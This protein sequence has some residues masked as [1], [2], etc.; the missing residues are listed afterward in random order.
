M[1][2]LP[3]CLAMVLVGFVLTSSSYAQKDILGDLNCDGL[4]NDVDKNDLSIILFSGQFDPDADLNQDGVVNFLDILPMLNLCRFALGDGN[5]DGEVNFE[6]LS[7][8]SS[9]MNVYNRQYDFDGDGDVDNIDVVPFLDAI[10]GVANSGIIGD[11]NGD[12]LINDADENDLVGRLISGACDPL[13]DLNQDGVVNF[14]DIDLIQDLCEFSLGDGD[15]NRL[16]NSL[17]INGFVDALSSY[18]RQYDFNGDGVVDSAGDLNAFF[19][20]LGS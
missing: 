7:G 5:G 2:F 15:G 17:D 1:K 18:D 6:D 20:V 4:V 9:A 12:C 19:K 8:F 3:G 11:L 13:A 16:F 10:N 14:S